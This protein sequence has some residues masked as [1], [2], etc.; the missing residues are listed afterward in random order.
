[1]VTICLNMIVK[2]E[3]K[4]IERLLK[5]VLP[6]IDTYC[7][8]DTGSTDDTKKIIKTFF[9]KVNIKG[10]IIE[11]P[12]KNFGYNRTFALKEAKNMADYLLFLDADMQLEIDKSFD[13]NKLVHDCYHINQGNKNLTYS[14]LR[15]ARTDVEIECVGYT[16]EYYSVKKQNHTQQ[17]LDSLHINDIGD[18]GCKQNKFTRD[19]DLLEEYLTIDPN[20]VRTH[21][22][23][24]NTYLSLGNTDKSIEHYKKRIELGGWKEENWYSRYKLGQCYYSKGNH[25]KA[26]YTWMDAYNYKPNRAEPLYEIVKH[27]RI[28]SKYY[29]SYQFYRIAKSIPYPENDLLFIHKDIYDFRLDY[30]FSI[31][32]YY[33]DKKLDIRNIFVKLFNCDIINFGNIISNYKFYTKSL[34]SCKISSVDIF[35]HKKITDIMKEKYKNFNVSTPSIIKYKD[36]YLVNLRLVNYI[37]QNNGVYKYNNDDSNDYTTKTS[38]I[39]VFLDKN[40]NIIKS[41][42]YIS[43][44]EY[45]CRIKGL[46]DIRLFYFNGDVYYTSTKQFCDNDNLSIGVVSGKYNIYLDKLIYKKLESPNSRNCEKNW[47]MFENSCKLKIVYEWFPLTIYD[48]NT[49]NI[50]LDKDSK[51][52]RKSPELFKH[53]R[54]STNGFKYDNELWFL[55][56]LVSFEGSRNYYHIFVI[57]DNKTLEIKRYSYPFKFDNSYNIEYT[58]GLIIDDK[59]IIISH[60]SNDDKG[61]ISVYDRQKVLNNMFS[62]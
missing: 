37:I 30:E 5:S 29:L 28:I 41:H 9:D 45:N 14:N 59:N 60:S 32:C 48:F 21:F 3:S 22:Y 35:N 47:V 2:N 31:I 8:C 12:F 33:I 26:I 42:N 56:H 46:E 20:C 25:E 16:H 38:N 13:K 58:L 54:G 15:L 61:K 10:K 4:I 34:D 51:L 52:E 24:A 36:G 18:G 40:L 1:M 43:E 17:R 27:Y 6:I 23:L 11:E 49:E 50:L 7:I 53:L 39:A 44:E 62:L 57:L 19:R 55:C